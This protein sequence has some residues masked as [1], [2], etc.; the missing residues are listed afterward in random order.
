M[1]WTNKAKLLIK[2]GLWR[3]S[4]APVS[5][6]HH[7]CNQHQPGTYDSNWVE[8]VVQK[9]HRICCSGHGLVVDC[10][11]DCFNKRGKESLFLKA[12]INVLDCSCSCSSWWIFSVNLGGFWREGQGKGNRLNCICTPFPTFFQFYLCPAFCTVQAKMNSEP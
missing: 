2:G 12:L 8:S 4:Q 11:Y 3:N 1:C 6:E 5:G 7:L 9:A 10:G